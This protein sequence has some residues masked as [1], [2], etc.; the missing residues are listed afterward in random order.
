MLRGEAV[1]F[2]VTVPNADRIPRDLHAHYIPNIDAHRKVTGFFALTTDIT[3]RKQTERALQESLAEFRALADNSHATITLSDEQRFIYVNPRAEEVTGYTQTELLGMK[4]ADLLPSDMRQ[5]IVERAQA[6]LRGGDVSHHYELPFLRK[7]GEPRWLDV[8]A[9]VVEI[10]GQML[11]LATGIDVTERKKAEV[12]AATLRDQLARVTRLAT[13]GE[14]TSTL[15]H[16]VN[17]P[18]TAIATNA[19]VSCRWLDEE[20]L[21]RA[22]LRAA[23]DDIAADALRAGTIIHRL[24]TLVQKHPTEQRP[25][26]LNDLMQEVVQLVASDLRL[27]TIDVRFDLAVDLPLVIGDGVQLQQ[28]VLNLLVNAIDAIDKTG[29]TGGGK[30]VLRTARADGGVEVAVEDN[31]GGFDRPAPKGSSTPS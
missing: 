13:L 10:G 16:E 15:A 30:I 2:E 25:V 5:V 14:L 3:E 6:R 9:T 26:D 22:A 8:T 12:A 1:E 21:D 23:L 28:V 19:Q 17:Q 18:L 20:P 27:K 29:D 31:G 11:S 24:R 7:D 4:F